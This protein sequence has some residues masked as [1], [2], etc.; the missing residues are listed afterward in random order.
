MG[1]GGSVIGVMGEGLLCKRPMLPKD[2]EERTFYADAGEGPSGR[3][4]G[5]VGSIC[6]VLGRTQRASSAPVGKPACLEQ[7]GHKEKGN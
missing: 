3:G 1:E 5:G 7:S 4:W 6:R 2:L